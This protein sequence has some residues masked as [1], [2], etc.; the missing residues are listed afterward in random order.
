MLQS[1]LIL[2]V[3][4]FKCTMKQMLSIIPFAEWETNAYRCSFVKVTRL[5][6]RTAEFYNQVLG[7]LGLYSGSVACLPHPQSSSCPL[8]PYI[9]WRELSPEALGRPEFHSVPHT[10]TG[11]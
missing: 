1:H 8:P 10:L 11:L 7:L 3:V 4:N 6:H 9:L 5:R 2:F